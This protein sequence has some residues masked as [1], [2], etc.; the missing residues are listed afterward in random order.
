MENRDH[1]RQFNAGDIVRHFKRETADQSGNDFLYEIVGEAE[2]SEDGSKVM[3]YR[4]LYGDKKLYVRPLD[5]FMS[6]TDHEKYPDIRQKYRFE[7]E[8]T[9]TCE[10]SFTS[11]VSDEGACVDSM[12]ADYGDIQPDDPDENTFSVYM[13]S[14]VAAGID[15]GKPYAYYNAASPIPVSSVEKDGSKVIVHFVL[16]KAPMLTWLKELRNAPAKIHLNV[17][18]N[19]PFKG[20][21]R[22]GRDMVIQASYHC[23]A[24]SWKDLYNEELAQFED[25]RDTIDYQYHKGTVP[26]L[27]VYF[28][29]NG[30]GDLGSCRTH[31][32]AAQILANRGGAAFVHDTREVFGDAH[33]MAFQ[34]PDMWYHA[35]RDGLMKIC[36]DEIEEV[37]QREGI[38]RS[39]IYLAGISA[40]G[41]MSV[42]MIAEY[43]DLFRSAMITCPA[44]DAANA[45]SHTED[46]N[47]TDAE[48]ASLKNAKTSIWLVQGETDSA[49]DPELCSKRIWQFLS[50]GEKVT[51][52]RFEGDRG[53][54]SPFTTYETEDG[55]YLMSLFETSDLAEITGISGEKRP[56]GKISTAQDYSR[57]G[58]YSE[59][60]YNDHWT[61]VFTFRNIPCSEDGTHIFEWAV[62]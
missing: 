3:V 28:H 35:K 15:E 48:L 46:A 62:K 51:E 6:E 29:G 52:T 37:I 18:Q 39:R 49:V 45:R 47:L 10:V 5:M 53:I 55:K 26:S 20:H 56:G 30:E 40:G 44:L 4:A 13:T 31:N 1:K 32:N 50:E 24:K 22:D 8:D 58:K 17:V 23:S 60:K 36:F 12:I 21:T 59:V 25:V 33:V 61:W 27:I 14:T 16:A 19:R 38:D 34:A 2:N 41:F 57:S 11:F 42:R 54:G 7:K 9:Q 43:P